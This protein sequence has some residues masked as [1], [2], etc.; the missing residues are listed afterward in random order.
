MSGKTANAWKWASR[1]V[2]SLSSMLGLCS[3]FTGDYWLPYKY[4]TTSSTSSQTTLV[5]EFNLWKTTSLMAMQI[6]F[7]HG[8]ANE[9]CP[10]ANTDLCN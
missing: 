2:V 10:V 9:L 1:T 6:I 8:D 4:T 3:G 7:V 5:I